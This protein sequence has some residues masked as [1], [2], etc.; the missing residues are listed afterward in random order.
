MTFPKTNCRGGRPRPP[1]L[2][3]NAH[4]N[5]IGGAMWAS[6]PT[7]CCP[8]DL[9]LAMQ[10]GTPPR[11]E[12][13]RQAHTKAAFGYAPDLLAYFPPSRTE[14]P[15]HTYSMAAGSLHDLTKNLTAHLRHILCVV[16]P[17]K[18]VQKP[19]RPSSLYGFPLCTLFS[20]T[21]HLHRLLTVLR[22][23]LRVCWPT[24]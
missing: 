23:T 15:C 4:G 16:L 18:P 11:G 2:L 13:Q 24:M 12:G 19:V 1:G 14:I 5:D 17:K 7:F 8:S 21:P 10:R 9:R 22:R 6:P 20:L 3:Q